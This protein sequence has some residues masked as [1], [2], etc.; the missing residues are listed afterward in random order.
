MCRQEQDARTSKRESIRSVVRMVMAHRNDALLI[1]NVG[2]KVVFQDFGPS[3]GTSLDLVNNSIKVISGGVYEINMNI[4]VSVPNFST[5]PLNSEVLFILMTLPL[6]SFKKVN[7]WYHI[8]RIRFH[9]VSDKYA[10]CRKNN[11]A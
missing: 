4:T 2:E 5:K 11:T 6:H 3:L 7:L 10:Y 8:C 1:A 9:C